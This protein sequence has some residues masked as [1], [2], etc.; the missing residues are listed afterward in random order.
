VAD[1]EQ[2]RLDITRAQGRVG[3]P[4]GAKKEGNNRKRLQLRLDVPGY[5]PSD[6]GQ[7][8]A[9]LAAAPAGRSA[10]WPAADELLQSLIGEEIRTVAGNPNMVL[11]VHGDTALVRTERSPDGQP[12]GVGEVQKG[13]D[14]LAMHRSIRVSVDELGH[15]SAFVGAV[16]ATLPG[17]LVTENPATI[18]LGA[19]IRQQAAGD[20]DF[21]VLDGVAQTKIRKEQGQLRSLLAGDRTHAACALCG[22]EYPMHF[23]VAG[24]VKK[25]AVCTDEERRDLH[26]VAMLACSFGCDALYEAGRITVNEKGLVETVSVA[27][28]PDGKLREQMKHLDG[29]RCTAHSRDSAPYFAWHRT[30]MFRGTSASEL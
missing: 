13:M 22:H 18:S 21:A 16:L 3:L 1:V 29:L 5:G 28:V 26:H 8:A 2:L 6:A 23:L 9:D 14:K 7:L 4:A 24:H 19:S 10:V 11:A 25:R 15:R 30:T 12:V 27:G 17:A 20:P